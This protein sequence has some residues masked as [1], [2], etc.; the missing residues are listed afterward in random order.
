MIQDVGAI[1]LFL[2][3]IVTG[4]FALLTAFRKRQ[5]EKIKFEPITLIIVLLTITTLT[6][7][8]LWGDNFKGRIWVYAEVTNK[9]FP[10]QKH[11]LTL[12]QN[13]SYKVRVNEIE[14]TCT[15]SEQYSIMGDTIIL[16]NEIA[17]RTDSNF[18]DR[19]LFVDGKLIPIVN[20]LDTLKR[21]WRLT[22]ADGK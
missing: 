8:R 6:V 3:I 21:P 11:S 22:K 4:I 5:T 10:V 9:N 13:K 12:R 15:Y 7:C 14:W 1:A 19:Y 16:N 17:K 18:I 20:R 2:G